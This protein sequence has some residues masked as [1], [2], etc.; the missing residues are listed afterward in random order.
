MR[1]DVVDIGPVRPLES[2]VEP[3]IQIKGASKRLTGRYGRRLVVFVLVLSDVLL[4]LL[5]WGAA[6]VIQSLW[7]DGPLTEIAS[8]S[9]IS[10]V[11]V[12]IGLRAL[13]G[14]Y[15]GYG[16]DEVEVLRR[17]TY[18]VLSTLAITAV[19]AVV[20]HIGDSLSRLLLVVGFAGLILLGPLVRHVTKAAARMLGIWGK[21]IVIL[22]SGQNQGRVRDAVAK[23]LEDKWEL[24]YRPV[25]VVNCRLPR[26]ASTRGSQG[27]QYPQE[28]FETVLE[29]V[30]EIARRQKIDTAI[31]AMPHTRRE[32][33]VD[34]VGQASIYFKHVIVLPNLGGITNSA[35]V[36]RDL[37]GNFGVE[38]K[39]NLLD[40][41]SRITKRSLDLLATLAGGLLISPMLLA[42]VVLI[43]LDS[44]GPILY[45]HH[46]LGS[47]GERFRCWK[48][49]TMRVD[50]DRLLEEFLLNNP[51]SRAEWEENFKLR[52]DPRVTRIGG[53]L[54]KTSLDELP[55]LWNV[56]KGDMSLVGPRPIVD[57]EVSRYGTVYGMYKRIRPGISGFWQVSGRSSTSYEE[58]VRLDAYYVHNWSV[59]LD[60]VI[61][62]R[63]VQSVLRRRGAY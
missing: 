14:L 43:K 49:R 7:G 30:A 60:L 41:G 53:F 63:T 51:D 15:P 17:Q 39:H 42:L 59:W 13:M 38:I 62:A 26:P 34:L 52:N 57:A 4:S 45:G 2:Y 16:L 18:S 19:F 1:N 12:W 25:A 32:Q 3:A 40:P 48:F 10:N 58:R 31:F 27:I 9:I 23:L 22:G 55:Q 46:R 5:V 50:G 36:A 29:N 44:A 6:L 24:G 47:K 11:V 21:P 28:P 56:L 35:V 37:A 61:L 33:L 20:F 8:A 54:R